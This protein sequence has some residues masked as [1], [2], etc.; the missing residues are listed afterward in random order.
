MTAL[1]SP[2]FVVVGAGIAGL[3]AAKILSEN[4]K[5]VLLVEKSNSAGGRVKTDKYEGFLLDHG[6]QVL[7]TA[8]PEVHNHLDL[9]SLDLKPFEPGATIFK[10]GTFSKIC[11][12]FRNFSSIAST[13]FTKAITFHDKIKMLQLRHKLI[14]GGSF[15]SN[16]NDDQRIIETLDRFGFSAK[17][18]ES[19]FKPLIGGIQLDPELN[20]SARLSLLILKM[21]FLGDAA[22]PERGMG[23]ISQQLLRKVGENNVLLNAPVEKIEGKKIF[24]SEGGSFS[25]SNLIIATESPA[26]AKL[27]GNEI[28]PSKS[29][30]CVY[31]SAPEAPTRSRAILL[32]GENRGPGLNVAIMTNVSSSYSSTNDALIAVAI[33]GRLVCDSTEPVVKQMKKWFGDMVDDWKHLKTFSIEHGQPALRPKDSFRKEIKISDGVFMCGDHRDTPSIQGAMVSGRRTAELCL[34][35]QI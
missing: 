3:T 24:T 12:P 10:N 17:A 30:S 32:N 11:D 16:R 18:I 7:L 14:K 5:E 34:K 1:S 9:S 31:F 29:V 26:A 15:C 28:P 22:V 19:F 13:M 20:G 27:F 6:F 21:L 2:E 33:P 35:Q 23:S 4:N 25:P 8:Y